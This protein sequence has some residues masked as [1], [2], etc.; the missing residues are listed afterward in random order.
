MGLKEPFRKACDDV[1]STAKKV[2]DSVKNEYKKNQ[3]TKELDDMYLMLGKIRF[4]ELSEQ[5]D[6]TEE[7]EKIF[8]EICRLKTE[9]SSFGS[10]E[11]KSVICEVCGKELPVDVVFCP[12]CGT[13]IKKEDTEN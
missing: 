2:S 11:D 10:T 4:S 3:L 8:A 9:L 7:S 5:K 1:K 12:F 6:S 13:E